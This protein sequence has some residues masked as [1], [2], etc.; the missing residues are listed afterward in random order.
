MGV[1][2][3]GKT[4]FSRALGERLAHFIV[5]EAD[6][7]HSL[8]SK[9]K[10]E[11]GIPLNDNDRYPWLLSISSELR[12]NENVILACSA[13]K[14]AYRDIIFD[15]IP[16]HNIL[17]LFLDIYPEDSYSR[18][19]KRNVGFFNPQL[20]VSQFQALEIPEESEN[21][22]HLLF[23]RDFTSMDKLLEKVVSL[24]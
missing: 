1:A 7:F 6:D 23:S 24:I 22:K 9:E 3:C 13:L 14:K 12:S 19:K 11:K 4:T 17:V 16:R 8:G 10:M 18:L 20:C 21:Y 2:G 15:G 5:V